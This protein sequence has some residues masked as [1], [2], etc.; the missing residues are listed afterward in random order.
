MR[1]ASRSGNLLRVS[2]TAKFF[3]WLAGGSLFLFITALGTNARTT[4]W[5]AE[6]RI[7]VR[8]MS[9]MVFVFAA[10]GAAVALL[11]S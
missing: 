4:T 6:Y 11:V 8:R 1:S 2:T 9:G 10:V 7:S 3:L 5:A